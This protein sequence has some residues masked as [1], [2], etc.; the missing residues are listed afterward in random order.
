MNHSSLN[1]HRVTTIQKETREIKA[2]GQ[3]LATMTLLIRSDDGG[4]VE[5]LLFGLGKEPLEIVS[6]DEGK[7]ESR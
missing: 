1:I 7:E 5:I 6:L 4:L 3:G 2:G